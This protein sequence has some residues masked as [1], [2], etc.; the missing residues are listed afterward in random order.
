MLQM[1]HPEKPF[2]T[3]W[4]PK[5]TREEL[6]EKAGTQLEQPNWHLTIQR[7]TNQ[8]YLHARKHVVTQAQFKVDLYDNSLDSHIMSSP[9]WSNRSVSLSLTELTRWQT[10]SLI[11]V[12]WGWNVTTFFLQKKHLLYTLLGACEQAGFWHLLQR[13][14][15]G[16]CSCCSWPINCWAWKFKQTTSPHRLS[17]SC[18]QSPAGLDISQNLYLFSNIWCSTFDITSLQVEPP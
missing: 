13:K 9:I 5:K 3:S 6:I 2:V 14:L 17:N 11:A 12:I 1:A 18:I 10:P 8:D 4:L 15:Q 7:L 16:S